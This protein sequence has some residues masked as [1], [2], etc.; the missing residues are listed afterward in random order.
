MELGIAHYQENRIISV[1]FYGFGKNWWVKEREKAF[2]EITRQLGLD[3]HCFVDTSSQLP[4]QQ[5]QWSKNH[6]KALIAWL[7]TLPAQ[8]GLIAAN[9]SQ[10]VRVLNT[11]RKIG[12]A[13]PEQMAILGIDNDEFLCN[14]VMPSLSSV[15]HNVEMVGY[16]AAELLNRRMT[17]P[18]TKRKSDAKTN[19]VFVPPR[20]VVVRNSSKISVVGDEDVAVALRFIAERAL[21]GINVSEVVNH[22]GVSRATLYRRFYQVLNRSPHDEIVRI[23]VE[24]A[25]FL[26]AKTNMSIGAIAGKSCY[27]AIEYFTA[28]FR[29]HTGQTPASYRRDAW[30]FNFP[31]VHDE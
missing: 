8:T 13:V 24:H 1:A 11:C 6:E 7:K 14:L 31:D 9:D 2:L 26:L 3:S 4:T 15:D 29:R 23:R 19:T 5:P 10:A 21:L 22:V 20:G 25:K 18:R 28:V 17:G 16:K 30:K 27:P 12:I